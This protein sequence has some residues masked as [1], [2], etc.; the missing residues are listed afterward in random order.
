MFPSALTSPGACVIAALTN[1][2]LVFVFT[3]SL[4]AA[5]FATVSP[6]G[7]S[8]TVTP[9]ILIKSFEKDQYLM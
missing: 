4:N 9:L 8:N 5:T 2:S 6:L 7:P 1:V 3:K